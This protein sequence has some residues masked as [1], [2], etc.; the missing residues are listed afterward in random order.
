MDIEKQIQEKYA[1]VVALVKQRRGVER[2]NITPTV[3][4][5]AQLQRRMSVGGYFVNI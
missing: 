4:D 2:K 3:K 5:K 1:D